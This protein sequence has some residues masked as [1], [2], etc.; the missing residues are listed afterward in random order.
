MTGRSLLPFA[1]TGEQAAGVNSFLCE[2]FQA[3]EEYSIGDFV[4][5]NVKGGRE[6]TELRSG[7]YDHVQSVAGSV[8]PGRQP[9]GSSQD[10]ADGDGRC[11]R[12]ES[13]DH[14]RKRRHIQLE[15]CQQAVPEHAEKAVPYLADAACQRAREVSFCCFLVGECGVGSRT[16]IACGLS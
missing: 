12:G 7:A 10:R 8:R 11:F 15:A 3:Y 9:D 5:Q 14:P 13:Q 1:V 4:T 6:T 16:G 2:W